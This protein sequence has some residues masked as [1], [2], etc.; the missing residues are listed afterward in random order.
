ML[1]LGV[2]WE[3]GMARKE[4]KDFP[5]WGGMEASADISFNDSVVNTKVKFDGLWLLSSK[6]VEISKKTGRLS[7]KFK[8]IAYSCLLGNV[9][10]TPLFH[11]FQIP[12]LP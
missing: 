12:F 4:R 3:G 8:S 2:G 1:S 6:D 11:R 7:S 9:R 10:M 5:L